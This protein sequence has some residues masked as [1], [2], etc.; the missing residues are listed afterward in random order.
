MEG[1]VFIKLVVLSFEIWFGECLFRV[2]VV[3][4]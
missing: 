2:F 3:C 1:Y 4:E